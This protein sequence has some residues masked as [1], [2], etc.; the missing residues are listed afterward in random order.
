MTLP[1]AL[2]QAYEKNPDLNANRAQLRATDEGPAIVRAQGLP[3]LQAAAQFS[4]MLDKGLNNPTLPTDT[5]TGSGTFSVPIYQG[6][7]I[8]NGIAAA[9]QRVIAGRHDLDA[10]E[11]NLF[12]QVVAAYLGVMHD[13]A[14]VGLNQKNVDALGVNLKATDARFQ[15]GDLT[16]T[17]VAQSNQRLEQARAQLFQAQVQL[18]ASRER[19]VRLV[20][21]APG[22]LAPPQPLVGLPATADEA[23]N[24][25]LRNNPDLLAADVKARAAH[26][27][28]N[29]AYGLRLP[30]ISAFGS[31]QYNRYSD[32]FDGTAF[33]TSGGVSF[34]NQVPGCYDHDHTATVGAQVTIP[35]Y[36][37]GGPAA[38]VRRAQ[39]LESQA[40][41]NANSVNRAVIET[42]RDAFYAWQASGAIIASSQNAVASA[43]QSLTGVRAENKIGTRTIIDLLN[44]EQELLSTQ[45]QLVSARRDAYIAAFNLLTAMGQAQARNLGIDAD[46]LYDS[47]A[48]YRRVGGSIW[49]WGSDPA[50]VAQSSTT[51]IV[52]IQDGLLR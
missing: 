52:P 51:T 19:Y 36:Q 10:V 13:E 15:K 24:V 49:D 16:K 5:L 27:D 46:H 41:E 8:R 33:C 18:D 4:H 3:S 47:T 20:G 50:P 32:P 14:V 28:T 1:E 31:Y 42:A 45:V 11:A 39:A 6:G 44:A 2:A 26:Y 25:A 9:K 17:D 23:I 7:S 35:L 43:E 40:L 21:A 38:Q 48:H 29:S 12:A 30:K 22:V 37:G 34:T